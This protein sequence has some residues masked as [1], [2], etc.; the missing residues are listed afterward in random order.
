MNEVNPVPVMGNIHLAAQTMQALAEAGVPVCWFHGIANGLP[1]KNVT[2]REA[3]S[4]PCG[5]GS[6]PD[7]AVPAGKAV[8]LTPDA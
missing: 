8:N 1:T 5:A 7:G 2:L 3:Q 4:K 6:G